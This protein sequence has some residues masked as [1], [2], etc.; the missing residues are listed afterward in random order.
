MDISQDANN[1]LQNIS[2]ITQPFP[3]ILVFVASENFG[4]TGPYPTKTT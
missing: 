3:K 1:Y 4:H 2:K